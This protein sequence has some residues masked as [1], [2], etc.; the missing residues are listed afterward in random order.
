MM[1]KKMMPTFI[2]LLFGFSGLLKVEAFS[3]P[4]NKKYIRSHY[5]FFES[6]FKSYVESQPAEQK[7][8]LYSIAGKVLYY[9]EMKKEALGYLQ[10]A[11]KEK[12]EENISQ[13]LVMLIHISKDLKMNGLLTEYT[14]M[15]KDSGKVNRYLATYSKLNGKQGIQSLQHELD[16]IPVGLRNEVYWANYKFL[17]EQGDFKEA[18]S[19]IKK[20]KLVHRADFNSLFE[21]DVLNLAINKNTPLSCI[22]KLKKFKKSYSYGVIGCNILK[23]WRN[24]DKFKEGFTDLDKYFEHFDHERRYVSKLLKYLLS[25]KSYR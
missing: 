10:K 22:S 23:D 3:F 9:N 25:K 13:H 11:L 20:K 19:F 17:V 24:G 21:R 15:A 5:N 4:Q 7:F 6:K 14:K 16:K 2:I 8:Y 18:I 12:K 1:F